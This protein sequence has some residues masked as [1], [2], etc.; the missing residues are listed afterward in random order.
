MDSL[1]AQ[2]RAP[3][4]MIQV[5]SHEARFIRHIEMAIGEEGIESF[6]ESILSSTSLNQSRHIVRNTETILSRQSLVEEG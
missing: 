3:H 1:N 6:D 2:V 5:R 4:P